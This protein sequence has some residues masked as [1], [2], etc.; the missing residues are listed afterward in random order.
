MRRW[1][2]GGVRL[3]GAGRVAWRSWAVGGKCACTRGTAAASSTGSGAPAP[4]ASPPRRGSPPHLQQQNF[5][6]RDAKRLAGAGV[7]TIKLDIDPGNA[8]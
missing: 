2:R 4:R 8:T 5:G 7:A 1:G 3:S 6:K